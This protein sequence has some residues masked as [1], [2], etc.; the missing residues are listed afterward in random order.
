M[1]VENVRAHIHQYG[2]NTLYT[3]WIHHGEEELV[4]TAVDVV[5][6]LVDEM[7]AVIHDVAR[8]N[9]DDDMIG[10]VQVVMLDDEQ[11]DEFK[12]SLIRARIS[13]VPGLY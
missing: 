8:I 11:H 10:D 9:D 5:S 4:G 12:R 6:E 13:I 1:P 7:V 2:F 3:N